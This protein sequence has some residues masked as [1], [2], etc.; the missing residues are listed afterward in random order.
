MRGHAVVAQPAGVDARRHEAVAQRVHLDQRR[1]LASCRRSRSGTGRG[2][3]TG[4]S[5]AR[6][7]RSGSPCPSSLC[8]DE[9]ERQAGE[10]AAAADAADHHV[11]E[12]A[13]QLH[14]LLRLQA[15]DGL[16]QHHVVQ[17]AA[18]RVLGVLAGDGRLD[19]LA[20]GDAQAAGAVGI[21]GQ[22]LPAGVGLLDG[23]GD[24]AARPRCASSSGGTASA[25][26][27]P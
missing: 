12:V 4:R 3:S 13:D 27:S 24:D 8:A 9:G 10:I 17:H 6:R 14:L 2:S 15:D 5:A 20:D 26:S 18:E 25:G 21:G 19:R 22:D 23:A 7:P 16:V 1:Q 11:G